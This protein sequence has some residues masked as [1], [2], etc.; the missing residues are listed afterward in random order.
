MA[1]SHWLIKN[2]QYVYEAFR[3]IHYQKIKKFFFNFKID[4]MNNVHWTSNNIVWRP[5]NGDALCISVLFQKKN[6]IQWGI[7]TLCVSDRHRYSQGVIYL[8]ILKIF[9]KCTFNKKPCFLIEVSF[10]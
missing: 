8:K 5:P 2:N 1:N 10:L 9:I 6:N 3:A 4:A 7:S